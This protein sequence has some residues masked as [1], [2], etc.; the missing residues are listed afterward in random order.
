M[1]QGA[2]REIADEAFFDVTEPSRTKA[3]AVAAYADCIGP[4]FLDQN[5]AGQDSGTGFGTHPVLG[6][7]PVE[8]RSV[9]QHR[10]NMAGDLRPVL[11]TDVPAAAKVFGRDVVSRTMFGIDRGKNVDRGGDLRSGCQIAPESLF[12]RPRESG[13]PEYL[14]WLGGPRFPL[15]RK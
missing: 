1:A 12:S 15:S 5:Q 11:G 2:G 4:P 7:P 8:R 6:H 10:V 3:V 13:G 9:P 14:V